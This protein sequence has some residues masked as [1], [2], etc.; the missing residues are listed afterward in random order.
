MKSMSKSSELPFTTTI[1]VRDL[2]LCLHVQRAARSV[3][4]CY[5]DALRPVGLTS[6][7][8]S[9][10]MALNRPEPPQLG[11]VAAVLGLDRTT[12]TANLKPLVRR[13][14][15]KISVDAAD[16]RGRRLRLM[17][18]G[19]T[20]LVTAMPMWRAAQAAIQRRLKGSNVDRLRADLK[21]LS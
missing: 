20:T 16:K 9:L 13:G 7:Q 17:A 21:A 14:F 10:L 3:A 6:G 5:D 11:E 15:L 4:R 2:C 19:R 8:F 1:D 12:L 18:K